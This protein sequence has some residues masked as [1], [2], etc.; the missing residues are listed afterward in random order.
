[1]PRSSTS[2]LRLVSTLHCVDRTL[3]P[4]RWSFAHSHHP[5]PGRIATTAVQDVFTNTVLTLDRRLGAASGPFAPSTRW[6]TPAQDTA[7]A[8]TKAALAGVRAWAGV[9]RG[10]PTSLRSGTVRLA[11][12]RSLIEVHLHLQLHVRDTPSSPSVVQVMRGEPLG[13][14]LKVL[15]TPDVRVALGRGAVATPPDASVSS[16]AGVQ[17]PTSGVTRAIPPLAASAVD[18]RV[19]EWEVNT[20]VNWACGS[21]VTA[22]VSRPHA[23]SV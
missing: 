2:W 5:C 4:A 12:R 22:E 7:R 20:H 3:L 23:P 11:H 18:V 17:L 10:P 9:V 14:P 21:V 6:L 16:G 1:V 15:T 8:I 13:A 19:V